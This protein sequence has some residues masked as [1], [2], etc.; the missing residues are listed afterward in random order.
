MRGLPVSIPLLHQIL[1]DQGL[2]L[3]EIIEPVDDS[4]PPAAASSSSVA[5]LPP[6]RS[7]SDRE[8]TLRQVLADAEAEELSSN[9]LPTPVVASKSSKQPV[10]NPAPPVPEPNGLAALEDPIKL[11]EEL[12]RSDDIKATAGGPVVP[13]NGL[14]E[15]SLR[16][17]ID[18]SE[19]SPL[20]Y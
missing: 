1:D 14:H 7:I 16:R 8:A 2:P 10:S 19:R 17:A 13:V 18:S 20:F 3:I 11:V 15:V 12:L 9:P 6:P 4:P 5:Q